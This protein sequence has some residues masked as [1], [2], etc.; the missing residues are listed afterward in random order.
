[1]KKLAILPLMII[2]LI[3]CAT[4]PL[5]RSQLELFSDESMN[6]MGDE[7]YK[8]IK[9]EFPKDKKETDTVYVSCVSRAIIAQ[10]DPSWRH[11]DWEI[12][13]F[14]DETPNAFALPGGKIGVNSG[15]LKVAKNQDQLATVIGHEIAHV[16]SRHANERLST[17]YAAQT[18]VTIVSVIAGGSPES[19]SVVGLLGAGVQY[20]VI[21]PF[22]RTQESEADLYGLDLMAQAG[23]NPAESVALWKNMEAASKDAQ[24]PAFLLTHPSHDTRIEDLDERIPHAKLLQEEANDRGLHPHCKD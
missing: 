14:E 21:L 7:A 24:P 1:M 4:S 10:L 16:L 19:Q 12:T 13:V 3:A 6:E 20:G 23:F 17:Q 18:G 22:S 15:M 8:E 2:A 11:L 9:A 5:G